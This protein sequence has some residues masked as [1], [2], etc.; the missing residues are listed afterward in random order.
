MA[1]GGIS[2]TLRR[3][4]PLVGI[5]STWDS[6][7]G[8]S[9]RQTEVC[10]RFVPGFRRHGRCNGDGAAKPAAWFYFRARQAKKRNSSSSKRLLTDGVARASWLGF[11]GVDDFLGQQISCKIIG[12]GRRQVAEVVCRQPGL[13]IRTDSRQTTLVVA[14]KSE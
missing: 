4:Y 14:E 2:K 1:M 6:R 10:R 11:G 3:T 8:R 12:S 5:I 9:V 13:P 7:S